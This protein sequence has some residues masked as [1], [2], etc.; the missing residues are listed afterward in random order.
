MKKLIPLIA[1]LVVFAACQKTTEREVSPTATTETTTYSAP[2]VDTA[3]VE[4][5]V[6]STTAAAETAARDAAHK[7]GT[8]METAGREIQ[9]QA[10]TKTD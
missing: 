1:L 6:E 8:A 2:S 10:K 7:T 3:A 9:E 4:T 5:A